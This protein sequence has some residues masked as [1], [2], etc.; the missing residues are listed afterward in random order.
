MK[1]TTKNLIANIAAALVGALFIFSA[2]TKLLPIS[3]FEYLI[4]SQISVSKTLASIAARF[5]IG[6]EAT[7][8]LLLILQFILKRKWVI[9]SSIVLLV[10][11][12]IHLTLLWMNEGND[13]NCGCMGTL[14]PMK[15]I[16]SIAKNIGLILLLVLSY[17]WMNPLRKIR[18]PNIY[19]LLCILLGTGAFYLAYPMKSASEYLA[20]SNMY[21]TEQPEQPKVDIRSGKR[22]LCFMT[23]G[24]GHCR[25]A[26][27]AITAINENNPDIPFYFVMLYPKDTT[28]IDQQLFDFLED[29][30][31]YK[32]PFHFIDTKTFVD[33]I[34]ASGNTGTP[35]IL[36][37]QDS[38]IIRDIRTDN[39]Q[40]KEIETWLKSK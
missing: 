5:F 7:L 3:E 35:T 18:V 13:V 10:A 29:T 19:L 8:G 30:K 31:S 12:S 9:T 1:A 27:K 21:L 20:L 40:Q 24:C 22:V 14:I 37:M 11:F 23:L 4:Q 28:N 36:W 15:P 38:T 17:S 16:P 32:I 6:I 25:D 2:I 33:Y 26:A 39:I 34:Q